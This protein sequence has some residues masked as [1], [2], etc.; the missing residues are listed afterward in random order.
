MATVTE[1][2]YLRAGDFYFGSGSVRIKTLLG[3]C[4]AITMWHPLKRIGG[5]CHY[6]LP[7][8]GSV[9]RTLHSAAGFYADEVLSLFTAAL[10]YH[11]TQPAEYQV[12]VFGG[13][14]MFPGRAGYGCDARHPC[15]DERRE[16]CPHVGCHNISSA[17]RLL[18]AGGFHITSEDVGGHGSRSLIFDLDDGTLWVSRG[19]AMNVP[20]LGAGEGLR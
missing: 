16:A 1:L 18:A 7:T 15:S 6:L 13:G 8:R 20:A 5:M 14:N 3:T 9:Q 2:V 10:V 17:H 4:I 19:A 11:R 12:K